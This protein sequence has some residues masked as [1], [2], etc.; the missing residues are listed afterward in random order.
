M[1]SVEGGGLSSCAV[2]SVPVSLCGR[3]REFQ[4]P[5]TEERSELNEFRR[6]IDKEVYNDVFRMDH[7]GITSQVRGGVRH[8][9]VGETILVFGRVWDY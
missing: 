5:R 4:A 6:M 2:G 1:S 8:D 7:I 3:V 9:L